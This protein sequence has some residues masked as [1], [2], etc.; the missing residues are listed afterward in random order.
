MTWLSQGLLLQLSCPVIRCGWHLRLGP[1]LPSE[2]EALKTRLLTAVLVSGLALI[3]NGWEEA[4]WTMLISLLTAALVT[5]RARRAL[6][7]K[8]AGKK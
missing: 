4:L 8:A 7:L 6:K 2:A 1:A 5:H 3:H